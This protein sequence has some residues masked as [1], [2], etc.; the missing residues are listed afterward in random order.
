MHPQ[1]GADVDMTAIDDSKMYPVLEI[2]FR[3]N[4]W[5]SMPPFLSRT[6]YDVYAAGLNAS[7]IWDWGEERKGSYVTP[8]GERTS[9]DRYTID[10][11]EMV[12]TN[13]DNGRKRSVRW[14][15]VC[16][17]DVTK[18]WSGQIKPAKKSNT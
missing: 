13:S 18:S 17:G 7:Y 4:M 2:A 1:N 16:E 10:W 3:N 5:W 6:I 11:D 12:Q 8:D 15:W 14:V 9:I